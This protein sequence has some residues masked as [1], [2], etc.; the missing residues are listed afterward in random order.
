MIFWAAA[1]VALSAMFIPLGPQVTEAQ[2]VAQI[3]E[4]SS[5]ILFGTGVIGLAI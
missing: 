2:A 4:P 3:I 5:P 1:A